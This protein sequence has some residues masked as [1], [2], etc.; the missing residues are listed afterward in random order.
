MINEPTFLPRQRVKRE[1]APK[2]KPTI[3]LRK[4]DAKLQKT[5]TSGK[6]PT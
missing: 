1:S 5:L 2:S 4:Q 3:Y 6:K